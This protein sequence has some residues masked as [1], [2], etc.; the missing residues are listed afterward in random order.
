MDSKIEQTTLCEL[1]LRNKLYHFH[2]FLSYYTH[3]L[4][5]LLRKL[6]I[7]GSKNTKTR[8]QHVPKF[9]NLVGKMAE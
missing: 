8:V 5:N 6:K 4:V 1:L 7:Q 9:Q 2:I 3:K